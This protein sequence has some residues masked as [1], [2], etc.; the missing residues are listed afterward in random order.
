MSFSNR[1]REACHAKLLLGKDIAATMDVSPNTI[2]SYMTGKNSPSLEFLEAFCVHYGIDLAWLVAGVGTIDGQPPQGSSDNIVMVPRYNVFASAGKG[3][4]VLNE[5]PSGYMA[6]QRDW[7]E[8]MHLTAEGLFV[9]GVVGDSME[10]SLHDGDSI[11]VDRNITDVQSGAAY[12]FRQDNELLVKYL[13]RMPGNLLRVSSENKNYPS[14][15]IDMNQY[16]ESVQIIGR[17]ACS[18]H[19]WL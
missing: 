11:L 4:S 6:F 13:Q 7:L 5:E 15:D 9:I 12:V 2:S 1:F 17:V 19:S 18:M 16:A 14:Y 3:A 8:R 10:G